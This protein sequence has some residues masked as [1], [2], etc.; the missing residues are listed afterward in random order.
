[1]APG[2]I[3]GSTAANER[4]ADLAGIT[5]PIIPG[6]PSR[7]TR[8]VEREGS[9]AMTIGEHEKFLKIW[10]S[11]PISLEPRDAKARLAKLKRR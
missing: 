8:V 6:I 1:M 4:L 5:L 7:L 9:K 2:E 11:D 3:D 10:H